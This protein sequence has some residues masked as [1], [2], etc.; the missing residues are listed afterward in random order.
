MYIYTHIYIY[1]Y[2]Y[3]CFIYYVYVCR[4]YY[5]YKQHYIVR[6]MHVVNITDNT[7]KKVRPSE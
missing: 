4:V 6:E 1:I 2:I 7:T 3:I 5:R